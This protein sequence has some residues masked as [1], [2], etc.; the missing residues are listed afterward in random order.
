MTG[1]VVESRS[2]VYVMEGNNV[3][4][5]R[6]VLETLGCIPKTFPRV[7]EFLEDGDLA[8]T[9]KAFAINPN[10]LGIWSD[11]TLVNKPGETDAVKDKEVLL[12]DQQPKTR[13]TPDNSMLGEQYQARQLASS[14]GTRQPKGQCDPES[15]L[16][17]SCPRRAFADPPDKLPMPATDSNRKALETWIKEYYKAGAFNMCKRQYWPVTAGPPMK[18]HTNENA[19]RIYCRKPTKVPLHFREEVRAGLEADVK[20][21]VLE[22]VAVGEKDTWCS[23]MVIQPKKN[24]RPRRP[25]D[26]SGLSRVGRHESHH[27]PQISRRN[28]QDSPSR[29][30][31]VHLGLCGWVPRGR[32]GQG[33]P[34]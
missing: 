34:P 4:V 22:R 27:Q 11:G 1:E 20:K 10:P 2:L 19:T 15:D 33:G 9:G 24:G 28:S 8:L 12:S 26:L 25:V 23:R 7:G 31:K 30:A 3:L 29:Q 18:I 5:S 17:C 6:A 32:A 13:L 21:G 14:A 16:P